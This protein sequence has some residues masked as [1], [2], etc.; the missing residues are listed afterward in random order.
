MP[1]AS[2]SL[3]TGSTCLIPF[4]RIIVTSNGSLTGG[5]I[6]FISLLG[7]IDIFITQSCILLKGHCT[8]FDGD[9]RMHGMVPN[10]VQRLCKFLT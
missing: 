4:C 9:V 6:V 3:T 2:M 8:I 7:G 10:A 5:G 1:V